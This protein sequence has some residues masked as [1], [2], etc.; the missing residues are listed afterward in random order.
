MEGWLVLVVVL[1][2]CFGEGSGQCSN[3]QQAS[4]ARWSGASPEQAA[5]VFVYAASGEEESLI[6]ACLARCRELPVCAGVSVA[7]SRGHCTGVAAETHELLRADNDVAY[8][9]KICAIVPEG[10]AE[11]WWVVDATP[12]YHLHSES[13]IK[14]VLNTTARECYALVLSTRGDQLYRSAQWVSAE[15]ALDADAVKTSESSLGNCILNAEDK[16]TEPESYRVAN[17]YTFYVENQC[18]HDYPKKIDRCSYEEYYNQTLKHV[19]FTYRNFTKDECKSACESESR[20]VCRG[21]TWQ[22][23]PGSAGGRG[24]AGNP[25]ARGLCDLHSEDLVSTGSWLLR[26]ANHAVYYRRVICLNI[27]VDCS[28][29]SLIVTYR[30]RGQ[31][32][33]RIYVPG[34]GEGCGVR[35]G[36]GA[37]R[38]QLPLYGDCDVNFAHAI[39][40][41]PTGVVNR[42]MAYVMVMIQNNPI[43]QTAGDR[44]VRVGCA[45]GERAAAGP[46]HVNA[47]VAVK[48]T[49]RPSEP[50]SGAPLPASASTVY[51]GGAPVSMYVV[52]AAQDAPP[53]AAVSLG[54]P[55]EM[56]IESTEDAEIEAY[57]LVAS[58]RLGDSSVLL[59]D[60]RGCPTGQVDFPAFT[61]SVSGGTQRL[62][63]RFKAFR[64]PTS[65]V[66]RFALMVRFCDKTCDPVNCIQPSARKARMSVSNATFSWDDGDGVAARG[67]DGADGA[68]GADGAWGVV[69]QGGAAPCLSA[70]GRLPLELEMVVGS[71]DVVSADTMVRADHRSNIPEEP[72]ELH[73]GLVC[74]HELLLVALALA[75]R[76]VQV[77]LLMGC[78]VLVKR[79][80]KLAEMN[81]QKDYQAFDN[82]GFDSMS[83]HRRV[84]WPDQNIDVLQ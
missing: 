62:S 35:G 82:I 17:Y 37:V 8:F 3:G 1:V 7:Y 31:F 60:S 54:E 57:H 64:F 40:H 15:G 69:A 73:S 56:R 5:P 22:A 45:P 46:K 59:L 24:E 12:G 30:P 9:K 74:V 20:F 66:V 6:G 32:R 10:C 47:A 36:G 38:L 70:A 79:Y 80:R 26:R 42:T 76:A 84:H 28:D 71:G 49:G 4:F 18:R 27:S 55:L 65:H 13:N 51:G 63:A 77:L 53:A 2:Q 39:S 25:G 50:S 21:F 16:F 19:E 61:R 33:G 68:N 83:T 43:I 44:W 29:D 41:T 14:V 11:R 48:D 67:A 23:R 34:R 52:R 58:S 75:W 81:M 78:C 72:R